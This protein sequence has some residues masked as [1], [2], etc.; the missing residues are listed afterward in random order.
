MARIAINAGE[1]IRLGGAELVAGMPAAVLIQT[2][3]R[4]ALSYLIKPLRDQIALT[5]REE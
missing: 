1:L 5:F 3:A 2:E 4:S